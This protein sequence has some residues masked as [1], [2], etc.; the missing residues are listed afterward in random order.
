MAALPLDRSYK[1]FVGEAAGCSKSSLPCPPRQSCHKTKKNHGL[2][3]FTSGDTFILI[4]QHESSHPVKQ[5]VAACPPIECIKTKGSF[6]SL[7]LVCHIFPRA[8]VLFLCSAKHR[9]KMDAFLDYRW[10]S[11]SQVQFRIRLR[12]IPEMSRLVSRKI[13]STK[14]GFQ[15]RHTPINTS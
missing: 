15:L 3:I 10:R 12:P 5:S 4:K 14:S 2:H 6:R 9:H 11:H 7:G 13:S 1:V 8:H